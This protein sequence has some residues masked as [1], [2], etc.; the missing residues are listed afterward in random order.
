GAEG[1][2]V[3]R[4]VAEDEDDLVLL[5][6]LLVGRHRPRRLVAVLDADELDLLAVD[7]ALL[8]EVLH[9]VDAALGDVL[10]LFRGGPGEIDE[11]A[12][13]DAVLGAGRRRDQDRGGEA[14]QEGHDGQATHT[15]HC[16]LLLTGSGVATLPGALPWTME[17]TRGSAPSVRV[18]PQRPV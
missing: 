7:A 11:V 12:E 8:V 13:L 4:P 15:V 14:E 9:R 3:G 6:E 10:A 2:G 16:G 5:H 18:G 17:I 1:L